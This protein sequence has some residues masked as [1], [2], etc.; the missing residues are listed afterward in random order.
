MQKALEPRRRFW[1]IAS[2]GVLFQGGAAAVDTST[3][4]AALV[5]GLTGSNFAVGAAAAIARCGWLAPQVIAGHFAQRRRRRLGFYVAGAFGRV[6]CLAGVAALVAGVGAQPGPAAIAAFFALWTAYAIVS[7]IVAVPYNDIA[8]RSIAS[9]RRSRMLA[10]RFF[11]GG[12]LALGVAVLAARLID[13]LAF[14]LGYAA[15]VAIAALLLLASALCFVSAGEPDAVLPVEPDRG[16]GAYLRAGIA[17][18]G[19]DRRLRQF[20]CAQWLG[21]AVAMALPFYILQAGSGPDA[22]SYVALLLGAQTAGA[23][24]SNPLWGWWGDVRGKRSLLQAAAAAD[25]GM[26]GELAHGISAGLVHAR[27]RAARGGRQWWHDCAARLPDG[28]LARR[29]PARVQRLLQRTR[30]ASGAAATG[31]R[32]GRRG[33]FGG[34]RVRHQCAGGRAAVPRRPPFA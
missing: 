33:G 8:A 32:S 19:S 11:G 7:G 9:E 12:V 17:V 25:A 21:G 18:F 34:R 31:R 1:R 15:V 28:D 5:H 4:I 13:G 30:G 3:I 26:A 10:I 6:A 14:P 29:T 16:F 2:A 20:V 23:L 24:L 27:L 22:S